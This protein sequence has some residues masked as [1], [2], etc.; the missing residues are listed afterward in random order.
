M[1]EQNAEGHMKP[2]KKKSAEKID[3]IISA[4]MAVALQM[5]HGSK[6]IYTDGGGFKVLG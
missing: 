1:I 6:Y 3:G 2:S 4:I 5:A